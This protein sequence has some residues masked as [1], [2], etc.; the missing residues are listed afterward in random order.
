MKLLTLSA[1]EFSNSAIDRLVVGSEHDSS[2]ENRETVL[3]KC[4]ICNQN[5]NNTRC[6]FCNS[7]VFLECPVAGPNWEHKNKKDSKK[8][9]VQTQDK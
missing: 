4:T 8:R 3:S 9:Q 1:H 7:R 6:N 2:Q 5:K